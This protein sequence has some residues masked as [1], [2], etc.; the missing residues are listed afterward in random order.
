MLSGF[1]PANGD[2]HSPQFSLAS[3]A[4]TFAILGGAIYLFDIFILILRLDSIYWYE[5]IFYIVFGLLASIVMIRTAFRVN[6]VDPPGAG[7]IVSHGI[8][9]TFIG[10]FVTEA[11]LASSFEY[12]TLWNLSLTNPAVVAFVLALAGFIMALSIR[13]P[14]I[15]W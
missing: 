6:A 9:M 2:R 3:V 15:T 1:V 5:I 12:S 13:G 14:R 10:F 8:V 7:L 11:G 4:K